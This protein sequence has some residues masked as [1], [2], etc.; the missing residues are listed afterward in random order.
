[1]KT[2]YETQATAIGG[3]AGSAASA[4]GALRGIGLSSHP[5]GGY[6]KVAQLAVTLDRLGIR[7]AAHVTHDIGSCTVA[8]SMTFST[9]LAGRP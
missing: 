2:L 1:L 7:Q 4:D 5:E 9:I 3:R 6:E 8:R